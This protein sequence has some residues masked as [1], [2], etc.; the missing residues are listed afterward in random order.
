MEEVEKYID[1]RG[2]KGWFGENWKQTERNATQ[3]AS[4]LLSR[5]KQAKTSVLEQLG[6]A[7]RRI[8]LCQVGLGFILAAEFGTIAYLSATH[9][10]LKEYEML[11]AFMLAFLPGTLSVVG[12][13][14]LDTR[15]YY[16]LAIKNAL[17]NALQNR[18]PQST[19][20]LENKL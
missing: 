2:F 11:P 17:Q 20:S 10:P 6:R 4:D 15:K 18:T 19:G 12:I 16:Y 8:N 13:A 3:A 5:Y 9:Y 14:K 7:V 1:V